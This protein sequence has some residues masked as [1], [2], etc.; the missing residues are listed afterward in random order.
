MQ[1]GHPPYILGLSQSPK[2]FALPNVVSSLSAL[3]EHG[4]R[5]KAFLPL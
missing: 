5:T 2:G 1:S 3:R 4:D